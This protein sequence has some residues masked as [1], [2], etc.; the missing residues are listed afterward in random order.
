MLF[1]DNSLKTK[2]ESF[3]NTLTEKELNFVY[4]SLIDYLDLLKYIV[5]LSRIS[6]NEGDKL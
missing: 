1:C 5:N 6:N 4:Q 3:I 2:Y